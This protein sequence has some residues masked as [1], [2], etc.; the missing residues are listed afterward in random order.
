MRLSVP[1]PVSPRPPC[2]SFASLTDCRKGLLHA[3]GL[4]LDTR[5][6]LPQHSDKLVVRIPKDKRKFEDDLLM[7]YGSVVF[8]A[9]SP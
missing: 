6:F 9:G 1:I 2:S 5:T 7:E 4:T 3:L 8:V